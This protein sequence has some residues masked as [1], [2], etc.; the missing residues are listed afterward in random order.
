MIQYNKYTVQQLFDEVILRLGENR[1][2]ENIDYLTVAYYLNEALEEIM[3]NFYP[4]KDWAFF[5][6]ILVANQQFLSPRFIKHVR[7]LLSANGQPPYVEAR[8]ID[9]REWYS[10]INRDMRQFWNM[11]TYDNPVY[12]IWG[13]VIYL[14][15]TNFWNA[16]DATQGNVSGVLDCYMFPVRV[17]NPNSMLNIPYEFEELL[18]LLALEKVVTRILPMAQKPKYLQQ[19]TAQKSI[20][21]QQYLSSRHAEKRHLASFVAPEVPLVPAPAEAGELQS[22]LS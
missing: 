17:F 4:I 7:L 22:R 2:A 5:T 10:I 13:N 14:Y 8:K 3:I 16:N 11:G 20:F 15:P 21:I 9:V 1:N 12:M 6:T 18:L 19:I